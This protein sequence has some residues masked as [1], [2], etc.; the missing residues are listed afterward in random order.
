VSRA[1]YLC[2]RRKCFLR[3]AGGRTDG[4]RIRNLFTLPAIKSILPLSPELAI[5][6]RVSEKKEITM[7]LHDGTPRHS[8]DGPRDA[9][10]NKPRASS[11]WKIFAAIVASVAA[12]VVLTDMHPF[13]DRSESPVNTTGSTKQPATV[14][15]GPQ[16]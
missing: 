11:G 13:A 5:K 1:S 3:A 10:G 12:L 8:F 9:Q 15:A 2:G 6:R 16:Q 14:P 7:T 4:S